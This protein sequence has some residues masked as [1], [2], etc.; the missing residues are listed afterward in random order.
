[1]KGSRKSA[2]FQKEKKRGPLIN[3]SRARPDTG[4]EAQAYNIELNLIDFPGL[5]FKHITDQ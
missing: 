4:R 2:K 1:M 3:V 5:T